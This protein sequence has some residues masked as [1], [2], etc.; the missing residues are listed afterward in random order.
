MHEKFKQKIIAAMMYTNQ[1]NDWISIER[2][3]NDIYVYNKFTVVP[4]ICD[5]LIQDGVLQINYCRHYDEDWSCH[6]L[7]TMY[8]ITKEYF[9]KYRNTI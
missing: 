6:H 9:D 8:K 1:D 7:I 3:C 2:L 5:E 4:K